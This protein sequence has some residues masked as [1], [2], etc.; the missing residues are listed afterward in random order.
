MKRKDSNWNR[1][2]CLIMTHV[3]LCFLVV[4]GGL[5]KKWVE[6]T[7]KTETSKTDS[8]A[9]LA[10]LYSDNTMDSWS[11]L[12]L[13]TLWLWFMVTF[14]QIHV[15]YPHLHT[16]PYRRP[17]SWVSSTSKQLKQNTS[18]SHF[19][20]VVVGVQSYLIYTYNAQITAKLRTIRWQSCERTPP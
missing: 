17:T 5:C 18:A 15:L 7:V 8:L 4:Q 1:I 13:C 16:L 3:T 14:A 12:H 19:N 2:C 9:Q 10:K 6:W 11:H 20:N